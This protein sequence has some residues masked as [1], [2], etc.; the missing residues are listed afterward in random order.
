MITAYCDLDNTLIYSKYHKFVDDTICIETY[1]DKPF[2]F[3]LEKDFKVFSEIMGCND[4]CI[5]PLTSRSSV[6]IDRLDFKQERSFP[7]FIYSNGGCMRLDGEFDKDW[8]EESLSLIENCKPGLELARSYLIYNSTRNFEVRCIDDLWLFTKLSDTASAKKDLESILSPNL[9]DVQC[10]RDKI[11]VIPKVL[12]KAN[13]IKRLEK[14]LKSDFT[15]AG[16]DSKL[17]EDMFR[18]VDLA[19]APTSLGCNL[20]NVINVDSEF[21]CSR[22]LEEVN[23]LRNKSFS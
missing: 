12:N 21:I 11:Y 9:F 13:A 22:L 19:V 2:S 15:I 4:I 3:M 23:S 14:R 6:Q 17:D 7:F 20:P 10:K 16:G 8:Y 5:V 1:Y 18:V